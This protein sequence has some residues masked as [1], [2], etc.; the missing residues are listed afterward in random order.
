MGTEKN[1]TKFRTIKIEVIKMK[2]ESAMAIFVVNLTIPRN[3]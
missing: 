2:S 1:Q 3:N